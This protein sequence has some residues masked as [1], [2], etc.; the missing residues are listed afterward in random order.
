MATNAFK[1]KLML[2][3][4]YFDIGYGVSSYFKYLIAFYGMSSL[5]VKTTMIIGLIYGLSCFV[6]GWVMYKYGFID[7][8]HEVQNIVNP[9]VKEMRAN[10]KNGNLEKSA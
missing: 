1:F 4:A 6:I 7:A 5:D 3:K 9:F 2:W 8:Q 10:F